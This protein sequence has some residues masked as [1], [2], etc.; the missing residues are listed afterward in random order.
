[1]SVYYCH[2]IPFHWSTLTFSQA[3]FHRQVKSPNKM[4]NE[5]YKLLSLSS[6]IWLD[7]IVS[8][9]SSF[10]LSALPLLL[11]WSWGWQQEPFSSLKYITTKECF[12]KDKKMQGAEL[13]RPFQVFCVRNKSK[14]GWLMMVHWLWLVTVK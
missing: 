4:K 5:L 9:A 14:A 7:L 2:S 8:E 3:S 13:Q 11:L 6:L 10:S 1:M 12:N